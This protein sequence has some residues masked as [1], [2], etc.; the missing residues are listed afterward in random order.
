MLDVKR[1]EAV[2]L[3]PLSWKEKLAYIGV[4]MLAGPQIEAPVMHFFQPGWY[5]REMFIPAGTLFIG[6]EHRHGHEC[7]LVKGTVLHI[8]ET[9]RQEITAPFTMHST[10]GY[11]MVLQTLT[12]VIGRTVHPNVGDA[13]D[14]DLLEDHIFRT[15]DEFKALG[16]LARDKVE[17]TRCL[18]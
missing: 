18:E 12:D 13:R 11:Q 16:Y 4:D 7:Q 3:A 10:P 2:E 5:I 6:R 8:T 14:I 9:G 15:L 17:R 1:L